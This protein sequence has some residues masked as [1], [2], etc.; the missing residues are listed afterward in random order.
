MLRS[1]DEEDAHLEAFGAFWMNY[2]KK[3]HRPKAKAEWISAIRRGVDPA[4]IVAAAQ[5]YARERAGKDPQ[6]TSYPANWLRNERYEDEFLPEPD[7]RPALFAVGSQ[8]A[9]RQQQQTDDLFDRAMA[10]AQARMQQ[11]TS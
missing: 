9:S 3:Q 10:R 8:P 5:S 11:E 2:P 1:E 7:G 6:Y 4:H